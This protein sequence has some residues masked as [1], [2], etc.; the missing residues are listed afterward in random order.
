MEKKKIKICFVTHSPP[1]FLGGV[2][3]FH[4]NLMDFLK[5]KEVEINW[6]YFG[7]TNKKYSIKNINY[8]GLRHFRFGPFTSFFEKFKLPRFFLKNHFDII[9]CSGGLWT[10]FFHKSKKQKLIHIYHGIVYYFNK[11]HFRRFNLFKKILFLPFFISGFLDEIPHKNAN[12]IIFVS[13]KV[14]KQFERLYGSNNIS[15]IVRTGVDLKNFK[16]RDKIKT[17]ILLNLNEKNFYG[18]Y[19]GNGGYWTKGLDRV[20]KL[21]EEIYKKDSS[22]RLILIGPDYKKVK[23][24]LDKDFIIFLEKVPRKDVPLYYSS[25]DLFFCASRY[26][27]GAPTLVV[28]EAMASGCLLICSKDSEQEIVR[29]LHNALIIENFDEEDAKKI[30]KTYKNNRLKDKIIKNSLDTIKNFSLE[31]WGNKLKKEI[32][33][34]N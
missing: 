31:K 19:I 30:L 16:K 17:K 22:F 4:K 11:N 29:D 23:S 2:S 5:S 14:K 20:I 34:K 10:K 18:L 13:E 26:E 27:G 33:G 12:K 24:L 25:S 32:I 21:S 8:I 6:I 3:L 28:S 9:V 15:K 7:K 1:E